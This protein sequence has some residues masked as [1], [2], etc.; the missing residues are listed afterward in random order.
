MIPGTSKIL[1]K[2][3]PGTLRII[4]KMLQI[5]EQLWNHPGKILFWSIWNSQKFEKI[6]NLYVLGTRCFLL[7]D[8]FWTCLEFLVFFWVYILKI[9]LRRWGIGNYTFSIIKQHPNLNLNFIAIKKTRNEFYPKLSYFQGWYPNVFY[10]QER[11]S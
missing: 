9:I 2:S 1:S 10:S 6:R 5:Q 4:T 7:F 11:Q 3:G 8:C